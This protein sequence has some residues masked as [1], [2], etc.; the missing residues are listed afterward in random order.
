MAKF[1]DLTGRT[2]GRLTATNQWER[3]TLPS[4]NTAI[5]YWCDCVCNKSKWVAASKL[6]SGHT[7]SCG[8]W[9]K[10]VLKESCVVT[11]PNYKSW[12]GMKQRCHNPKDKA[13]PRYGAKG[14]FVCERWRNDFW[15]FVED[16]GIRPPS[17]RH[18]HRIDND[19]GY[20]QGNCEWKEAKE[21]A[22][23]HNNG[24]FV[25]VNGLRDSLKATAKRIGMG[26]QTFQFWLK[27][28]FTAQEISDQAMLAV[29]GAGHRLFPTLI[30]K[31]NSS[32]DRVHDML[33]ALFNEV[34]DEALNRLSS[35]ALRTEA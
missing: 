11:H 16:M 8:C 31:K 35:Q 6:R 24:I 2:F 15:A 4:G 17:K 34:Q 28:G 9:H 20:E 22:V 30:I 26:H 29:R 1:L 33:E 7:Q 3:R 25:V 27:R 32:S 13:Y 12:D 14:I 23:H 19:R 21:H 18:I 5:Y 10:R